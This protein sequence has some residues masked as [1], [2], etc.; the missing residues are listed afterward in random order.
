MN[1]TLLLAAIMAPL[2]LAGPLPSPKN[3][4]PPHSPN[5]VLDFTEPSR[6]MTTTR[7]GLID[8]MNMKDKCKATFKSDKSKYKAAC[9][10][11]AE[12]DA[13][14]LCMLRALLGDATVECRGA[15]VR[16]M[17]F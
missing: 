2:A 17:E 6:T 7:R 8:D 12:E 5:H 3:F 13:K 10:E 11:V 1:L 4:R 16:S 14:N 15:M 9:A